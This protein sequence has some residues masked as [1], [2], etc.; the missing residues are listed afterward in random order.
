MVVRRLARTVLI[1]LELFTGVMAI[2]G[3]IGLL[4]GSWTQGLPVEALRWSLFTSYLIPAL[5]LLVFVGGSTFLGAYFLVRRDSLGIP[6]SILAGAILG[7]FEIVEYLVIGPMFFLQPLMFF[8]GLLLIA[9]G[10]LL[11]AQEG[12]VWPGLTWKW[13][14]S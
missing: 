13:L 14:R 11:W 12:V 2:V 4:T 10:A 1:A 9:L 5:A 3:T 6:V 7:I 8:I